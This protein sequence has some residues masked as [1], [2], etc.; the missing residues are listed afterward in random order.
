MFIRFAHNTFS[1]MSEAR[2]KAHVHVVI[3]GFSAVDGPCTIVDYS[4]DE[5]RPTASRVSR[6]SPYLVEG[7]SLTLSNRSR[8]LCNVPAMNYGS[9][10]IDKDRKLPTSKGLILSPA[11]RAA[12]LA[13]CPAA[14]SYIRRLYGAD[15]FINDTE[16]WC[17]WLVDAPPSLV[18]SS[19]LIAQHLDDV[20]RFRESSDREQTRELAKTPGLFGEIRQPS[21]PYL[22]VPKVSSENRH[23][24]PI[25]FLDP[26]AIASGSA[27]VVPDAT[28]F[29]FGVL[30]SEMH[31]AWMRRVCGRLESRYQYSANLVYN[32]FPWPQ[33]V[34][35]RQRGVVEACAEEV[36]AARDTFKGQTL[37]DLYDPLA[38]PKALRDAHKDLD[39]AVDKCYRAAP[40]TSERQRVE[41]LFELYQKLSAPLTA[42]AKKPRSSRNRAT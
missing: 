40:F 9:M 30:T 15:E 2:G 20:R 5:S 8:P 35:D 31:M 32:N 7:P 6:I 18:R 23:Y 3:I 24:L 42:P 41:Y 11:E 12:I 39:R 29:H 17:L 25:G 22:L 13:E 16:R 34:S 26:T 27:L 10:M 14:G 1:W 28:P 33:D 21:T 19:R 4:D 38:M 37:A 36:L